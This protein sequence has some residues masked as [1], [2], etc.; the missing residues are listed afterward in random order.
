MPDDDLVALAR[1]YA[2]IAREDYWHLP[3]E[4][5]TGVADEIERL[6]AQIETLRMHH[7][8]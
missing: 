2:L 1:D 7:G 8:F 6:R 4:F 3:S 5:F